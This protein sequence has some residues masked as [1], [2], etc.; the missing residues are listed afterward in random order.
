MAKRDY[1]SVLGVPRT[2]TR[3]EIRRAYR[4]LARA[5][6]PDLHPGDKETEERFKEINEAYH[7][8]SNDE[9]RRQYD[10]YGRVPEG[11]FEMPVDP[12]EGFGDIFDV[13]FGGG[14]RSRRGRRVSIAGEDI[15]CHTQ[16]S[17]SEALTGVRREIEFERRVE[18]EACS[19][20]GAEPGS[21]PETCPQCGGAGQVTQQQRTFFGTTIVTTTCNVCGGQGTAVR[22][23]CRKCGGAGRV[24]KTIKQKVDI[25]VGIE[26][27][28]TLQVPGGGC[29]GLRGGPP[30][31]LFVRV[32]V[33]RDP[34]FVRRGTEL[35]TEREFSF[36]ELALGTSLPIDSLDG[37][38][39]LDVAPGTQHGTDLVLHGKGMPDV[40]TGR[41]GDLHVVVRLVVPE[42][43]TDRQ[44]ELLR[45]FEAESGG[46]APKRRSRKSYFDRF[47]E[48]LR[49][50]G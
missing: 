39:E 6:H 45:E 9:D 32:G 8:L 30:G 38:V 40:G 23:R 27:G 15:R 43:L 19:G 10:R 21:K 5:S 12:F 46:A 33:A 48:S 4:K 37:T 42:E 18:C 3:E 36:P 22:E 17:L 31:D 28:G 7:V 25:P 13:F 20:S 34:R 50:D 16:I 1:Y 35:Y 24:V 26:D 2:A 47:K 41:R 44:R 49:G 14:A 11:G 29:D